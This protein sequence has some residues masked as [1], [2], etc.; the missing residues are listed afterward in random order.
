MTMLCMC[1]EPA[2][3]IG[4]KCYNCM[5][6]CYKPYQCAITVVF[7]SDPPRHIRLICDQYTANMLSTCNIYCINAILI[8]KLPMRYHRA[9]DVLSIHYLYDMTPCHALSTLCAR[10]YM[11]F[12]CYHY[13]IDMLAICCSSAFRGSPQCEKNYPNAISAPLYMPSICYGHG[14]NMMWTCY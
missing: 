2:A 3:N 9:N 14:A 5:R 10:S 12:R 1:Y 11:L 4:W 13:A 8:N 7:G 6:I